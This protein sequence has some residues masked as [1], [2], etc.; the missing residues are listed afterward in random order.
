MMKAL[1]LTQPWATLIALQAKGVETRGPWWYDYQGLVAIHAAKGFPGWARALCSTHPFNKYIHSTEYHDLPRAAILCVVETKKSILTGT[2]RPK[3]FDGM[4]AEFE[5]DF[6][7]YNPGRKAIPLDHIKTFDAPIPCRG[8]QGL[9]TL[10]DDIEK[11]IRATI[12][13]KE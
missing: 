1:T 12:G 2:W 10:P 7:D 5:E 11:L 4:G 9:W 8:A 3:D 13:A 6:G